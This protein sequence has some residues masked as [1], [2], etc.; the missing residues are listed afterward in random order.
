MARR[1]PGSGRVTG[2]EIMPLSLLDRP[3]I[4]VIFR[5]SGFFRDAFPALITAVDEAVRLV[6]E[7]DEPPEVDVRH[8]RLDREEGLEDPPLEDVM[9]KMFKG[10]VRV[11]EPEKAKEKEPEPEK[12]AHAG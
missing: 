3:R 2:F 7:L 10:K 1:I 8:L 5:I 12:A 11:P 4:D 6:A 9:R